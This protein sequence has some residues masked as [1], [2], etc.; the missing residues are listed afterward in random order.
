MLPG[1][2]RHVVVRAALAALLLAGVSGCTATSDDRTPPPAAGH[3]WN[4]TH[5]VDLAPGW[6]VTARNVGTTDESTSLSGP[7]STGCLVTAWSARPERYSRPV[8][9]HPVFVQGRQA[10]YGELD[11]DYGPYPRAVVWSDPDGRWLGVACDVDEA[12]VLQVAEGV[13]AGLNPMRVPFRLRSSIEGASMVQLIED[14]RGDVPTVSAQ[15]E[16]AGPGRTPTIEIGSGAQ[17]LREGPVERDRIGN[18]LVEIRRSSQSICLP[19]RADPICISGPGD[20]PA[21]D[22]SAPAYAVARRSA[23]L[24]EPLADPGDP[25]AWFDA[26]DAF[27]G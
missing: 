23:E 13:H 11:P 15:F 22:W 25:T 9:P 26:T 27:P 19:T 3:T 24:L 17:S 12:G 2:H 18:H 6:T 4:Q 20:E 16:T 7:G 10:S 1:T 8:S 5:R 21:S 14:R